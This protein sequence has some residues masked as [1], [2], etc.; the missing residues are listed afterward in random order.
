MASLIPD[1]HRDL[2][3]R[4]VVVTFVTLMADGQPQATPVWCDY[5]GEH[6]LINTARGRQKDRNVSA[7]SQVTVLSV[8]P[9]N[10]YRYLE[11]RGIVEMITED[12][13]VELITKL[14]KKYTGKDSYYGGVTPLEQKD[15]E[16]R[17]TLK[18]KPTRVIAH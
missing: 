8:D 11:V 12:G 17:V 7:R 5:D 13:A 2:L 3:D 9:N 4:P 10:P 14:A 16:T 6:V 1:T 18:I 15:K